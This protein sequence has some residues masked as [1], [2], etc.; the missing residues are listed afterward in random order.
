M[1]IPCA[2]LDAHAPRRLAQVLVV[3]RAAG[4]RGRRRAR[5]PS[6]PAWTDPGPDAPPPRP[7]GVGTVTREG[8]ARG[9]RETCDPRSGGI[10][11]DSE[12]VCPIAAGSHTH[13]ISGR[14]RRMRA[15]VCQEFAPIDQLVLEERPGPEPG[16]GQVVVAVRAAGVNYVDGL[17][18]QGKYQI[19]PPLPFTPGGEVAG[20]VVAVGEGVD[21]VAVGDRVLADALDGRVRQPRRPAGPQRRARSPARSPT[22]RRPGSCRATARCCSASRGARRLAPGEWV[23]VLGAGGGIGLGR[24]RRRHAPRRPRD[25]GGVVARE[26]GRRHGGGRRGH[27]R[28]RARGPQGASARAQRRWR[29]RRRRS[30]SATASPSRR[31]ARCGGWAATS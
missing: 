18:V 4:R 27:H 22:A 6:G 13:G 8:V 7:G 16:P 26:A 9:G 17:F 31:C 5:G 24:R 23:L 29:R 19:K 1:K 30:R 3:A 25:R 12:S 15:V 11:A 2:S 10:V 28:L 20:D 14:L 21:T